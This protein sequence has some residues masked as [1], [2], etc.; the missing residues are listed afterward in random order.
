MKRILISLIALIALIVFT[1]FIQAQDVSSVTNPTTQPFTKFIQYPNLKVIAY[2][3]PLSLAKATTN[4][5]LNGTIPATYLGDS[6]KVIGVAW[7]S[8]DTCQLTLSLQSKN[9]EF[10]GGSVTAAKWNTLA[11]LVTNQLNAGNDTLYSKFVLPRGTV[12]S[13][14]TDQVAGAYIGDQLR[15]KAVFGNPTT[16][17]N[18]GYLRIWV[19]LKK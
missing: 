19:Y 9:G 1:G 6:T 4:Y 11:T 18:G 16:V 17:G 13:G 3:I 12:A 15:V 8:D 10:T 2:S 5:S 14:V 7:Q